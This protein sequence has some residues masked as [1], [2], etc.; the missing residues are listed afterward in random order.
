MTQSVDAAVRGDSEDAPATASAR[1]VD[2]RASTRA[3]GPILLA[4][5][6]GT[7]S[8]AAE[9]L[10]IRMA[11]EAGVPL[12]IVHAIDPGRLR[13][14]GG[15]YRQRIDQARTAREPDAQ[16]IVRR[17]EAGGVQPQVL[18]WEGDPA[19]CVLDAARA[20]GAS[21]IVVGSHGRGRVGRALIGSVSARIAAGAACPVHVVRG[22]GDGHEVAIAMPGS[23]AAG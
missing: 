6:F 20:E 17:V 12:V 5:E 8:S 16:A 3:L 11:F 13:L 2:D 19:T 10:A 18:V 9:R 15:R 1:S 23:A 4:T 7:V 21:R 22:D 14:P